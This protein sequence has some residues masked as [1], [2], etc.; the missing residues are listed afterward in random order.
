[1]QPRLALAQPF[2]Q[3]HIR[4]IGEMRLLGAH[5]GF[6]QRKTAAQ[7]H[8]QNPQVRLGRFI[9]AEPPQSPAGFRLLSPIRGKK[10]HQQF[11]IFSEGV[12]RSVFHTPR[13]LQVIGVVNKQ[14]SAYAPYTWVTTY[15]PDY[16]L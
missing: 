6:A 15:P 2:Q 7:M 12:G 4:E 5:D 13:L 11:P 16:A 9:L 1:M 10:R 14:V 3:S 8:Q